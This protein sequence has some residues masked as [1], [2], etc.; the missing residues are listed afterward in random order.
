MGQILG[1]GTTHSPPLALPDTG[2]A[3]M[4]KEALTAPNADPRYRDP[5]HWPAA[6]AAEFGGDDGITASRQHRERLIANFRAQR[7]MLDAFK[8]DF[9]VIFG[10]DQYE[11]FRED[12]IPPFCI[13]GLDDD[14]QSQPWSRKRYAEAGNAWGEPNDWV[15]K[16][17]GHRDGARTHQQTHHL[18]GGRETQAECPPKALHRPFSLVV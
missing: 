6:M 10:D 16:L 13:Y 18:Y 8:P 11:N 17:R 3:K 14:F 4:F 9:I 5:A 7:R 15:F 12:I 2:S 1:M